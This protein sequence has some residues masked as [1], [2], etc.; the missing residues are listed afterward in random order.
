MM[1]VGLRAR[2]GDILVSAVIV[3]VGITGLIMTMDFPERAAMWSSWI[4]KLLILTAG[5]HLAM[6]LWKLRS[7]PEG[8]HSEESEQ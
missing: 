2:L 8:S 5:S 6:T 1:T 7:K 3:G 4:M